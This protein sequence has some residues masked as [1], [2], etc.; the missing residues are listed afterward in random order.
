VGL[1][2]SKKLQTRQGIAD[3]AMRLFVPEASIA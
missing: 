3:Q 2:E 1:R